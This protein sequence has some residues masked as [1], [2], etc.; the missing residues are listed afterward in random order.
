[1]NSRLRELFPRGSKSFYEANPDSPL[2]N[3][4]PEHDGDAAGKGVE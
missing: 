4:Q 1:L 2:P 3:A